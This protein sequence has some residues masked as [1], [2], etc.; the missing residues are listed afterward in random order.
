MLLGSRRGSK[1]GQQ[2]KKQDAG[3][4][5]NLTNQVLLTRILSSSRKWRCENGKGYDIED[6][7]TIDGIR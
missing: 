4:R 7:V 6:N 5:L 3:G 2:C 1:N